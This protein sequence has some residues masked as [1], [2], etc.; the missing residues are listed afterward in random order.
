LGEG[1]IT[2]VW[3]LYDE[4]GANYWNTS[5]QTGYWPSLYRLTPPALDLQPATAKGEPSPVICVAVTCTAA[6]TLQPGLTWSDGSAFTAADVVF[7]INTVL[8]F[9]LGLNWKQFYDPDVLD[10]AEALDKFNVKLYFKSHPTISD[11]QYG[12]LQGPIINRAFWQP[13]ILDAVNLLPDASLQNSIHELEAELAE[14]QAEL[15]GLNIA[16]TVASPEGVPDEDTVQKANHL[17]NNL[18]GVKNTLEKKRAELDSKLADARAA[19]FMVENDKEPTL[20]PWKFSSRSEGWYENQANFGTP[21]GNPWFDYVRYI[22]YP[23]ES[24]AVNALV[25][26][27]VDLVLT[28][29]GLSAESVSR[30]KDYP[31]ISLIRNLTR[32]GRFLAFNH[33]DS[34]LADPVLHQAL[35]CML[36]PALLVNSLGSDASPLS[37]YV[38]DD[39]WNPGVATLP[40]AIKTESGRLAEAVA[41][42]KGAGYSWVQEPA[43]GE[44]GNELKA[45]DGNI[46]PDVSLLTLQQDPMRGIAAIYIARQANILGLTVD[47]R[48]LSSDDLLYAVYSSR[49]Y[50]MALLGWRMATYPAYLCEWFAPP[51]QD[52]FAYNGSRH[53]SLCEAWAQVNEL[54][55]AKTYAFEI[56]SILMRDL[57]LIPLYANVRVDAFRNIHYPFTEVI[58]GLA[59]LYGATELAV[60]VP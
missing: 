52:P 4:P 1:T 35:A 3:A 16:L 27:K 57:P 31:E 53:T 59:G 19:L 7:T 32:S 42:L 2:N 34:Y 21:F 49:D 39:P 43:S 12:V 17:E 13:R 6:V 26:N 29:A 58:D 18:V 55:S 33:A 24:S 56:Q 36:D 40:C 30:L 11:W 50:D 41:L 14:M 22:S 38:L 15:D 37:A 23:D 5:T 47:V 44:S 46:L 25:N 60:P 9:R 45:P 54:D 28:Q 48:M 8:Q 20:G 10:H 51:G